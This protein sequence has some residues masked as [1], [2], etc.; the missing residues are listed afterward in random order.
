MD[1]RKKFLL[2]FNRGPAHDIMSLLS[3]I[4]V[5]MVLTCCVKA[6]ISVVEKKLLFQDTKPSRPWW[7]GCCSSIIVVY[8]ASC[9]DA[10]IYKEDWVPSS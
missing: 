5:K 8:K 9:I 2:P 6:V 7:R 3:N 10:K 4:I 1:K